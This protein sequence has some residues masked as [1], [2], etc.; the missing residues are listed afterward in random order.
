MNYNYKEIGKRIKSERKLLGKS[1]EELSGDL[2]VKRSTVG[3]WENGKT[4]PSLQTMINMCKMFNCEMG[5]L[6]CEEGYE[7]KTRKITDICRET[8]LSA[9]AVNLLM[10]YKKNGI[11]FPKNFINEFLLNENL[12]QELLNV[13]NTFST[14]STL[15]F[16][17]DDI[18]IGEKAY[19]EANR[20]YSYS[21]SES[22]SRGEKNTREIAKSIF[23]SGILSIGKDELTEKYFEY[24]VKQWE[25]RGIIKKETNTRGLFYILKAKESLKKD[26]RDFQFSI[27]PLIDKILCFDNYFKEKKENWKKLKAS[28][29]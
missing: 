21:I 26:I 22:S 23:D 3:S 29:G 10:E 13:E 6:L 24:I 1:Q 18:E 27:V 16:L 4:L 11:D 8:G 9:E 20:M 15:L 14:L 5:Y 17:E 25:E 12:Q 28:K 19:I 7:E 2:K